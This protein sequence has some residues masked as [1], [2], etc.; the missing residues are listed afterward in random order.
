MPLRVETW[1][2]AAKLEAQEIIRWYSERN[3]DAAAEFSLELDKTVGRILESPR[4]FLRLDSNLR[5][6]LFKTYPYAVIFRDNEEEIL[7]LAIA[8]GK[9]RPGYW[10][11][12]TL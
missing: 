5:R 12:R 3:P 7:I 4:R 11:K 9:R 6:A 8:H 2:P 10:R 1:H